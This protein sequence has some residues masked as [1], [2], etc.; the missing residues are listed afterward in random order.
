MW[1]NERV[2]TCSMSMKHASIGAST[3]AVPILKFASFE[4]GI[5]I[6]WRLR[7]AFHATNFLHPGLGPGIES[8]WLDAGTELGWLGTAIIYL[9][10]GLEVRSGTELCWFGSWDWLS[11]SYAGLY[12]HFSSPQSIKVPVWAMFYTPS[13][14]NSI[15]L[16]QSLI[17]VKWSW[18]LSTTWNR[19]QLFK[20][21]QW[22]SEATST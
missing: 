4:F 17:I 9:G 2:Y 16:S 10:M 15:T 21:W 20:P 22:W 19:M 18:P 13:C 5:V 6:F 11:L 12:A 8:C 14:W 1:K 3:V 7:S